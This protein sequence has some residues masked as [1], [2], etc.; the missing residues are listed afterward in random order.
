MTEFGS[1]H[2]VSTTVA[3][4]VLKA[5]ECLPKTGKP[6]GHEHTVLAGNSC[7]EASMVLNAQGQ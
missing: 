1:P 4:A 2:S 6:Q 5:F 3:G 7:T